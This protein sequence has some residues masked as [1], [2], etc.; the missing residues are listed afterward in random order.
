MNE[1]DISGAWQKLCLTQAQEFVV[2]GFTPG[3]H[4]IDSLLVG[5]Y[6]GRRLH[7]CASVRAGFVPASRRELSS[8][9]EPLITDR[10]PF[11]NV[12]ET[13]PGRWARVLRRRK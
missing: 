10:C 7:F 9:L 2:G 1:A 6:Q 11:A 8:R 3:D 12:P 5:I 4:G 13:S